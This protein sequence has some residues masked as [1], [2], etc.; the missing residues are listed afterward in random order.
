[1]E[2]PATKEKFQTDCQGVSPSVRTEK[3]GGEKPNWGAHGGK[4]TRS[5]RQNETRH[6]AGEKEERRGEQ[7]AA[8]RKKER[9]GEVRGS[10]G[11]EGE[12]RANS[13]PNRG[14]VT[15]RRDYTEGFRRGRGKG[16]GKEEGVSWKR[17]GCRKIKGGRKQQA[18]TEESPPES[19][20]GR[21]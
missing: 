17:T 18:I 6:G 15:G 12:V 8:G 14:Q 9:R 3:A 21:E 1:M 16:R 2:N 4:S 19:T 13:A 20:K 7:V 5:N 10:R 11:A